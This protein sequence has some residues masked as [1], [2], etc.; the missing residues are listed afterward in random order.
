MNLKTTW[1]LF[2]VFCLAV[3]I[4]LL[5]QWWN[6]PTTEER[7]Q[8]ERWLVGSWRDKTSDITRIAIERTREGS[9]KETLEFVKKD[10]KWRLVKP[11]EYKT[12]HNTVDSLLFDIT[13]TEADYT[14]PVPR[15]AEAVGLNP[16]RVIITLYAE[17]EKEPIQIRIGKESQGESPVLY[18]N[19]TFHSRAIAVRK[20]RLERIF[21]KLETF[22]AK[23]LLPSVSFGERLMSLSI[24]APARKL[25]MKNDNTYGWLFVTPPLGYA[26]ENKA[27]DLA[28]ALARIKVVRENGY[29]DEVDDAKLAR[30]GLKP[31]RASY[32]LTL[33]KKGS[34][35]K[36]ETTKHQL[37]IGD[38]DYASS[39]S[40]FSRWLAAFL[41]EQAGGN[42]LGGFAAWNVRQ[43]EQAED[44]RYYAK[45]DTDNYAVRVSGK[46]VRDLFPSKLD[47]YRDRHV[48][49]YDV[50]K[51]DALTLDYSTG[52]VKQVRL[53]RWQLPKDGEKPGDKATTQPVEWYL[54]T[55]KRGKLPTH[56]QV[57]AQL[58]E[59]LNNLELRDT[60]AFLDDSARQRAWFGQDPID[61]GLD[62]GK[63][64]C[65]LRI[66][67]EGVIRDKEGKPEGEGEPK[68]RDENKPLVTLRIGKHDEKRKVTYVERRLADQPPSILAVPDPAEN[69]SGISGPFL[70]HER[71]AGGYYYFR[72]RSIKSFVADY[73]HRLE[74]YRGGMTLL[75]EKEGNNWKIKKPFEAPAANIDALLTT[76][77]MMQVDK[78]VTDEAT[79]QDLQNTY[80]LGEKAWLRIRVWEQPKDQTNPNE[81]VYSI[82]KAIEKDGPEKGQY[83]AHLQ[84]KPA[85]ADQPESNKFVFLL[86]REVVRELDIEPRGGTI[87]EPNNTEAHEVHLRWRRQDKEGKPQ[88][89]VMHLAY[90]SEKPNEPKRWQVLSYSIQGQEQ[91][92]ETFKLDPAKLESL[93]ASLGWK[94]SA[95]NVAL[96]N[97][98]RFLQ[99]SGK[100]PAEYRLDPQ[101]AKS[102]PLLVIEVL[103]AE[104]KVRQQLI[105][106]GLWEPKVE[107]Y[108]G[109]KEKRYYFARASSLP[110]AV[111]VFPE[112]AWSSRVQGPEFLQGQ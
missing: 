15:E 91:K 62:A 45:L 112:G 55:Q 96:I 40:A 86:K 19:S 43:H 71:L 28:E 68:L 106:G 23:D 42:F 97:T 51:V 102:P 14:I 72:D 37:L 41:S 20:T 69:V 49:R 107:D 100:V 6:V 53:R 26:Q 89:I 63:E 8:R 1:I 109:L 83:Y 46:E 59:A 25:E 94:T 12:D 11:A 81:L 64:L 65:M 38:I 47:E 67:S 79:D 95:A 27:K 73:V 61:L 60:S 82:S 105:L 76:L 85:T 21:A 90:R 4:F 66:W 101:D 98:E 34:G 57:V 3:G 44:I 110:E 104:K 75:I 88:D 111:F 18:V 80:Q 36:D 16:P 58:V 5:L 2:G 56:P 93:L 52:V 9:V 13:G 87:F 31:D 70:L 78:L 17:K 7:S 33:E 50:K 30:W 35:E 39:A 10:G 48:V 77:K 103:D 74:F 99:Y 29:I 108:P 24:Q 54:Y 32:I 84:Y 22:R 92:K